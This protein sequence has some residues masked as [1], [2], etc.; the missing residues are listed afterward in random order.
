MPID[1]LDTST[2]DTAGFGTPL[3]ASSESLDG[4]G[5]ERPAAASNLIQSLLRLDLHRS[6]GLVAAHGGK[7]VSV[8]QL[9]RFALKDLSDGVW[10]LDAAGEVLFRNKVAVDLE[11][12]RWLVGEQAVSMW[13]A[14]LD[15]KLQS[16]LREWGRYCVEFELAASGVEIAAVNRVELQLSLVEGEDGNLLGMAIHS[17]DTSR[18]WSREQALQ[19]RHVELEHAYTQL[20]QAQVQL[21][22]SEKMASIGQLAAGVAHEINNPIGYVHSNLGTLKGYV[23][24]LLSLVAAYEELGEPSPQVAALR[25]KIDFDYLKGDLPQLVDES[26]EGISR[27]RKIV[28]DLRNFSHAGQLESEEWTMSDIHQGLESTLNIVWNE[29]KYKV[30][31]VREYADLPLIECMPAQLNQVFMN[32]LINAGQSIREQGRIVLSTRQ[33]DDEI[34]VRVADSGEGIAPDHLK[35]IFD[36]FFTTKPVGAGTGL[37]LSLSYGIIQKHHGSI[38]AESTLGVGTTFIV[39]LPIHQPEPDSAQGGEP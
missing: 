21:L 19:D 5:P 32:L 8:E 10:L 20:K 14:V 31:L 7:V 37:G 13:D 18:E 17:R 29:L 3:P 12:R 16:K 28:G 24:S 30:D 27:V 26:R 23:H 35:R 33:I 11:S 25:A 36:P 9:L 39:R 1:T 15:P 2:Q 38:R 4:A 22:Q 6:G 34:E